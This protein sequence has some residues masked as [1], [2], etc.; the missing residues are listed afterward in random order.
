MSAFVC[1]KI[2]MY[3]CILAVVLLGAWGFVSLHNSEKKLK[4]ARIECDRTGGVYV[5]S[6]QHCLYGVTVK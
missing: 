3:L 6:W 1:F 5:E 2:F 4:Q